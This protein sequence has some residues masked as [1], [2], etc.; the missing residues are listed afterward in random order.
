MF[1]WIVWVPVTGI[2][3]FEASGLPGIAWSE[4]ERERERKALTN[5]RGA[6]KAEGF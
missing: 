5:I 1:V 6:Y 3:G 2:G 4:R